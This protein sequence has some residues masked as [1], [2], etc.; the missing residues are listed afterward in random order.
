MNTPTAVPALPTVASA[1]PAGLRVVVALIGLPGAGKSTIARALEDHL[2]LRRICRDAIRAA[3]FPRCSYS[4]LEKRAAF[5]GVVQAL[6]I[7]C[8]LGVSSVLDGMTFAAQADYE[9]IVQAVE[10]FGFAMVPLWVDCSPERARERVR[11]DLEANR[12]RAADRTPDRVDE[13]HQRAQPPPS[14]ALRIDAEQ[15]ASAMC[16]EAVRLV[17]ARLQGETV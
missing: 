7:N 9:R 8:M 6:E 14:G 11:H 4:F 13:V 2:R 17:A 3:M 16:R 15:P 1:E 12:H 10:P 5:R